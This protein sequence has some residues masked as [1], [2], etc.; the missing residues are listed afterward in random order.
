MT[1]L[2]IYFR[3]TEPSLGFQKTERSEVPHVSIDTEP[4]IDF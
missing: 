3:L 4:V 2:R 1:Q